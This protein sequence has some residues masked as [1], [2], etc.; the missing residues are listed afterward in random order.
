MGSDAITLNFLKELDSAEC[1]MRV[2][3]RLDF[4]NDVM[5]SI[6]ILG[7]WHYWEGFP[8]QYSSEHFFV[9]NK[10]DFNKNR[11]FMCQ[12]VTSVS[13]SARPI[14]PLASMWP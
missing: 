14:H 11:Y 3:E 4:K 7:F 6:Q 10:K 13:Q 12:I 9:K 5:Q 1:S 2:L 8:L